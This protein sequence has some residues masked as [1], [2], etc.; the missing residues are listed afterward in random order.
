MFF[1]CNDMADDKKMSVFV[2]VGTTSFDQLIQTVSND[3]VLQVNYDDIHDR[4]YAFAICLN[5]YIPL[6]GRQ[7]SCV[8]LLSPSRTHLQ[9][10]CVVGNVIL[11]F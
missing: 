4:N 11:G 10:C 7:T 9:Y 2:T 1:F 8:L 5:L 6:C 3:T